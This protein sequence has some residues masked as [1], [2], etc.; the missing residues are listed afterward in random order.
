MSPRIYAGGLTSSATDTRSGLLCAPHGTITSACVIKS[1]II[2]QPFGYG[3]VEMGSTEE[4][5]EVILARNGIRMEGQ[6]LDVISVPGS[7]PW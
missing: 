7:S 4:A 1:K 3:C 5:K 2:G 6:R